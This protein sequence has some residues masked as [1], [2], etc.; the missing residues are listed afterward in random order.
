MSGGIS[1]FLTEE[2]KTE[3]GTKAG[4]AI[5][6]AVLNGGES[7]QAKNVVINGEK[8]YVAYEPL[9]LPQEMCV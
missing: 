2:I 1:K 4:D 9:R 3:I 8:Y 6:A 5:I 7:Y